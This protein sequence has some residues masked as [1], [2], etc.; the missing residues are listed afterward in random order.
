MPAPPIDARSQSARVLG[1]EPCGEDGVLLRIQPLQPIGP[2]RAGRFFMLRCRDDSSP[3]IPRP[4]SVY[5]QHA[6][7]SAEFLIKVTGLGTR[8]L[9]DSSPG[10]ELVCVGPLGNGFPEFEAG[11]PLVML[12][13]GIGSVP[14]YMVIQQALEGS[15]GARMAPEELTLIYG[16]RQAGYLYDLEAFMDLGVRVLAA[17]DDGSAGFHGN[18]LDCLRKQWEMGNLPE[19]V[20]LLTC[21]PEPMMEA[22]AREA[23]E[24]NLDCWL[25]LETYMACGVGI[26]NG[27]SLVTRPDG[28]MGD[29]PVAKACVD[30][31]V[32]H[33]SAIEL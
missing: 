19:A 29:W 33:T 10:T 14:F 27:C 5:R 28:P 3:C 1:V 11:T 21:G 25:S 32:F 12:A 8:A 15:Y 24:K 31:P 2:L 18:V 7:G 16:G 26:C 6:D 4:F 23:A 20:H 17:T 22:V 30:G 13:G 9:A